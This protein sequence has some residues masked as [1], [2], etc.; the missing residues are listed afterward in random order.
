MPRN[1][2]RSRAR[3]PRSGDFP[4]APRSKHSGMFR[5][6]KQP[7]KTF[8][9]REGGGEIILRPASSQHP[10]PGGG[11]FLF[12]SFLARPWAIMG[13]SF[14]VPEVAWTS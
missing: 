7:D 6:G 8:S 1:A 13:Y 5:L 14:P 9:S 2:L 10:P 4:A 3:G 11:S 12:R